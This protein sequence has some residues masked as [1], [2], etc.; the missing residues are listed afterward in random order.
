MPLIDLL[1]DAGI[2]TLKETPLKSGATRYLGASADLLTAIEVVGS[3]QAIRGLTITAVLNPG[4][5]D[6]ARRN[7]LLLDSVLR[8]LFPDWNGGYWIKVCFSRFDAMRAKLLRDHAHATL[9]Y[10]HGQSVIKLDFHPQTNTVALRV[11]L[12]GRHGSTALAA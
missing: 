5:E 12:K 1:K 6:A 11:V 7:G 10:T 2:E 4:N 9:E 8:T 3:M